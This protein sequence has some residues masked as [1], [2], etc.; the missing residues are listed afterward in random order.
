V[1]GDIASH[2]QYD[3]DGN[4][5][6]VQSGRA[7]YRYALDVARRNASVLNE[8]GPDGNI[9]FQYGL[10]L[11]S[12]SSSGSEQFYQADGVGSTANV[13]DTTDTL[14]ATYTYDPWGRLLNPVDPL[15]TTDKFKF[16]GEALDAQTGLYYLRARYY[17]PTVGQF[18]SRDPRGGTTG[19]PLSRNRYAYALANP[20][21][22][23]D[24]LG[25]AADTTG[26]DQGVLR[27][28]AIS[29]SIGGTTTS[30]F[31][32]NAELSAVTTSSTSINTG[33]LTPKMNN[34]N[35]FPQPG[36]SPSGSLII[37]TGKFI[38]G[39]ISPP[40]GVAAGLY[41]LGTDYA[42]G[43]TSNFLL[44]LA[45]LLLTDLGPAGAIIG[46]AGLFLNNSDAILGPV[47]DYLD[48][49]FGSWQFT[50]NPSPGG[51][52]DP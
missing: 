36:F 33:P 45:G 43:N 21:R 35:L 8:N 31:L 44:D 11:L 1:D 32:L 42:T 17:D 30:D 47:A 20:L 28:G 15:G 12:G 51:F 10:S 16:A 52:G 14:Q 37:D 38:G 48:N 23:T 39:L 26:G 6:L 9:D 24:T 4:R 18:I 3:G 7:A 29:N 46:G 2:Y 34:S 50:L 19:F 49:Q 22:Y 27:S 40:F 25:L 5:V 13:T 41:D